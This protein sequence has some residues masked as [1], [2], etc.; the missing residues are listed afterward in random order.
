MPGRSTVHRFPSESW[1]PRL[2]EADDLSEHEGGHHQQ[3]PRTCADSH[4]ADQRS[5]GGEDE[6]E[7][8]GRNSHTR[9]GLGPV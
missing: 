9:C 5:E 3:D 2:D 6:A 8:V 7:F 1:A 4:Q